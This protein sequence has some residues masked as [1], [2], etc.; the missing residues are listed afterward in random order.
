MIET[1]KA[2]GKT[3]PMTDDLKTPI[4]RLEGIT[5]WVI[6]EP[7]AIYDYINNEIRKEW[8]MDAIS[9]HRNPEDD[10]WLQ[11][12][13]KRY[14]NLKIVEMSRIKLDP[15]IMSYVDV[16]RGYAFR[17]SLA[18]RSRELRETLELGGLILPP[19]IVKKENMSLVD[20][21]CRYTTLRAMNI[22]RLYA[23]IGGF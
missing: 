11:N 16:D 8:E 18:K 14:W 23:Y 15:D 20:G 7:D 22:K 17:E 19:L 3:R 2:D 6:E 1:R 12:L 5:Y 4:R 21:Y 9:E 13:S 10:S